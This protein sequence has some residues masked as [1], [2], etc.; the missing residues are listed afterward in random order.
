[1]SLLDCM[2]F[3]LLSLTSFPGW[4]WRRL[5][6]DE[7]AARQRSVREQQPTNAS[8]RKQS[9]KKFEKKKQ[10]HSEFVQKKHFGED[11][12]RAVARR[13]LHDEVRAQSKRVLSEK[14]MEEEEEAAKEKIRQ[15]KLNCNSRRKDQ[16]RREKAP[17]HQTSM[18]PPCKSEIAKLANEIVDALNDVE[19]LKKYARAVLHPE[20]GLDC[21]PEAT[22]VDLL[23][24]QQAAAQIRAKR[25]VVRRKVLRP[26]RD[27][28]EVRGGRRA[29]CRSRTVKF[30]KAKAA[31]RAEVRGGRRGVSRSR[32]VNYYRAKAASRAEVLRR[33]KQWDGMS[34]VERIY[35][36]QVMNDVVQLREAGARLLHPERESE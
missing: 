13:Q 30:Y 19:A 12:A 10:Q 11:L 2:S 23:K 6:D 34:H 8:R 35:Y 7:K 32:T 3:V 28:A 31:S 15:Q 36:W 5:V 21:W 17:R 22:V 1:M 20:L 25:R 4:P 26:K 24:P 14:E 33:M 29:V 18:G 9:A 27:A 16:L